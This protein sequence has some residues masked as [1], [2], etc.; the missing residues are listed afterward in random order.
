MR[1]LGDNGSCIKNRYLMNTFHCGQSVRDQHE[2][3]TGLPT[4][5][6]FARNILI[7]EPVIAC[8]I[9]SVPPVM[10]ATWPSN[11]PMGVPSCLRCGAD[12]Y[13]SVPPSTLIDSPLM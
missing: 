2:H 1:A 4:N 7:G 11:R 13:A 3:V 9:T 12:R 8:M 10:N 5:G 6:L